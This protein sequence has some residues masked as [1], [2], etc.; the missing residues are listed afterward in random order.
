MWM[1]P[2]VGKGGVEGCIERYEI[3]V[4]WSRDEAQINY[5]CQLVGRSV[6]LLFWEDWGEMD[7][8]VV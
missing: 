5:V 3:S 4:R 7:F 2:E 8:L 6:L 1:F